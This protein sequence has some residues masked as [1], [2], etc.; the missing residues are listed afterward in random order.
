[1]ATASISRST[2]LPVSKAV[3]P[4]KKSTTV[5]RQRHPAT[6]TNPIARRDGKITKEIFR[7]LIHG[8]KHLLLDPYENVTGLTLHDAVTAGVSGK[9]FTHFV[10]S[11]HHVPRKD[12]LLVVG[13][14]ERTAQR[15]QQ[16]QAK[17]MDIN[18]S[19]RVLQLSKV[20]A[21]AAEELGSVE[22]AEQWLMEP[23]IGLE[24]RRPIDLMRTMDGIALVT[25][26]LARMRYGVYA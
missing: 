24:Q 22:A 25:Q 3:S 17:T 18:V 12:L 10:T 15:I 26:L 7:D 14:S 20:R 19:D 2:R 8:G 16:D 6:A 9:I 21:L 13:L 11:F 4:R 1:M 23:A 5:M